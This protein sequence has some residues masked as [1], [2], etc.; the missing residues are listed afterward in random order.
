LME[1][2]QQRWLYGLRYASSPSPGVI[3]T[4]DYRLFTLVQLE[5]EYQYDVETWPETALEIELTTWRK[6]TELALPEAAGNP[7]T[8]RLAQELRASADSDEAF[9]RAVMN[10]FSQQ[11]F[12]YTLQP[13]LLGDDPM[14]EFLFQTRRGFCEHYAYAF[15]MMMRA[16]GVPARIV[17][18]YMGGEVNPVNR[19]VI[20]HQFDAHA[21]AEVWL[22]GQGWVR[23]DPT[24][25]VAP[26]RIE[27][28]LEV[29]MEEEGSFLSSSPL[30]PLRYRGIN[31]LNSAR[32]RYD[33][34]TYQ[35]QAWVVNFNSDQ[36][37][38]LLSDVFGEVNPRKFVAVLLGTWVLVL[39][40]VGLSLLLRR[41]I[42]RLSLPDKHYLRFCDRLASMGMV[43][44][45]GE[46]PGD[47]AH[48][49]IRK[50]SRLEAE[51]TEITRC[52][53][54]LAY[55][56][57]DNPGSDAGKLTVAL[58]RHVRKFQFARP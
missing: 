15:V 2:T 16:A 27:Y 20:V 49:V 31:W 41:P 46:A 17:A 44:D 52:Y 45:P 58:G 40:P 48:R 22:E 4:P 53:Q 30:S 23:A 33:A 13:P 14:D 10:Y 7:L 29:A 1:P 35:W 9:V 34:L 8:R 5:D 3:K 38:K 43:R 6:E 39:L 24:A 51:V 25:A 55:A 47:F 28:G 18:G 42:H 21:W 12:F 11:P 50:F 19:T 26:E 36:Q 56:A 37:Y 32:L 57:E 54:A